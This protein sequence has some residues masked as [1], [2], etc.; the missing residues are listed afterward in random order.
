M[1]T[2]VL[3]EKLSLQGVIGVLTPHPARTRTRLLDSMKLSLNNNILSF[4]V[5]TGTEPIQ[6][7]TSEDRHP[8]KASLVSTLTSITRDDHLMAYL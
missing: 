3:I 7:L 4:L 2:T 1:T 8:P 5:P 6:L